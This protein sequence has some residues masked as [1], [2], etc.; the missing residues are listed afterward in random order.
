MI[1]R[2]KRSLAINLKHESGKALVL[3]LVK[4][5]DVLLQNYRPG[6]MEKLGLGYEA[7]R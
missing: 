4:T 3:Q 1:N 7:L 2:N 6:K 5:A